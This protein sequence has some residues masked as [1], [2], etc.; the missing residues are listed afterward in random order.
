M[1][2]PLVSA[3]LIGEEALHCSWHLD[4]SF[5]SAFEGTEI[6]DADL[7]VEAEITDDWSVCVSCSI[8]GS[9]KVLCDRCLGE[10]TL[11][12]EAAFELEDCQVGAALDLSQDI[13][14][15]VCTSLPLQRVHPEGGCDP[16]VVAHL[17]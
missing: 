2:R 15:F 17:G 14:D 13:Y 4:G 7:D 5:F 11:P 10:L 9:V 12:V 8:N 1:E 6:L 3:A 16:D